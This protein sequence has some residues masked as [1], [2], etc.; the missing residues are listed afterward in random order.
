MS[1]RQGRILV[2]G[3]MVVFTALLAMSAARHDEWV[4][5]AVT[6]LQLAVPMALAW[7][8]MATR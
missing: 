7:R 5:F 1:A 6:E 2:L 3:V 4:G 8:V